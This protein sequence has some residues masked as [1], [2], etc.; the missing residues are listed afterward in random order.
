MPL[1]VNLRVND[2]LGE[3]GWCAIFDA[4][5]DNP[6]NKIAEW[7]LSS[8][9]IN[10]TIA[11]SLAAYVAVSASLTSISLVANDLDAEAAKA[12]APAVA[13]SSSLTKLNARRNALG[14]EGEA[15]LQDAVRSKKGFE[16]LI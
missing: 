10:P 12:L 13:S 7:D 4:L 6:Q 9:G 15:A 8:Q 1:Q 2:S 16:L 5:R 11:T 14:S 3:E